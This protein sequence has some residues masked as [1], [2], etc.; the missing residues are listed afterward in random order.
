MN[1]KL[2][3]VKRE[4]KRNGLSILGVSEVRWT[5]QGDF[6]SDGVRIIYSGGEVHERGVAIMFDEEVAKR[7]TEVE[8]CSDR[9]IMIKVNAE[10]VNMVIIQCIC[11]TQ[12]IKMRK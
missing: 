4:M 5:G 1:G 7:I 11:P 2:E 3:E 8:Q 10:P 9:L 6:E 12:G